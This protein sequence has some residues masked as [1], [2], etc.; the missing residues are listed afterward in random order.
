[1]ILEINKLSLKPLV[2]EEAI[3]FSDSFKCVK[4]LLEIK[5]NHVKVEAMRYEDFIRVIIDVK[6]VLSLESAYSLKPFDYDL[7][8]SDEFHF[9][10]NK[11]DEDDDETI[12]INGNKINLDEYV[13]ELICASIPLSPKAKNEKLPSGGEGYNVYSEDEYDKLKDEE[14]D[15]RFDKLKDIEL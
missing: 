3:S 10:S 14:T 13:F 2:V 7:K 9:S 15:P 1:M 11:N 5:S 4:P 12:L 6:A 8:V